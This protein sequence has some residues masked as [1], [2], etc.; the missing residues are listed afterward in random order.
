MSIYGVPKPNYFQ[1]A[2]ISTK[3]TT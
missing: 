2:I 1:L 3:I